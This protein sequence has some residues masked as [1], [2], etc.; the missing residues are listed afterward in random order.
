MLQLTY[1]STAA[2]DICD[3]SID[4][5]LRVSRSKNSAAGVTGMLL[6]DGRR[7]LQALE[8][9]HATVMQTF[10]RIQID[11]RHK[12]VVMLSS[13][14][15]AI[16]SFGSWAMAAERLASQNSQDIGAMVEAMTEQVSDANIRATFRSFSRLRTPS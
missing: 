2:R 16:R 7:F 12:A 9:E 5:I 4:N 10:Q 14:E 8:G 11:R 3:A 6:Y 13:N 15:V 1:I